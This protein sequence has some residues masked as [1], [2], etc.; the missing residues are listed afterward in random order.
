MWFRF[1][2][3]ILGEEKGAIYVNV[4]LHDSEVFCMEE[5]DILLDE[6]PMEVAPMYDS[7]HSVEKTILLS[8]CKI[9]VL[10]FLKLPSNCNIL[11]ENAL[12]P[13]M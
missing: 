11:K 5:L 8:V 7:D 6:L 9:K 4:K 2:S 1:P 13:F 3:I 10:I 12:L